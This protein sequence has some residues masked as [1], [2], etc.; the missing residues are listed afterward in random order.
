MISCSI[1]NRHGASEKWSFP[2]RCEAF[3]FFFSDT[4]L[5]HWR[6]CAEHLHCKEQLLVHGISLNTRVAIS[7]FS[8]FVQNNAQKKTRKKL[9]VS[10]F[11][12]LCGKHQQKSANGILNH[13]AK[14]KLRRGFRNSCCKHSS[15][16]LGSCLNA[17]SQWIMK[18]KKRVPLI[19]SNR[20]S[21]NC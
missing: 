21:S 11:L 10:N 2:K 16:D 17:G 19:K 7:L 13:E 8:S 18:I 20:L 14:R 1:F 6:K 15:I 9:R 5:L 4:H 12:F 3:R